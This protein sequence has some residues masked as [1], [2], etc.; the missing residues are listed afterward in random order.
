MLLK[1]IKLI[2]FRQFYGEEEIDIATD[3]IKNVTLIHAENGVGKTTILNAILWCFYKETTTNFSEPSKIISNQALEENIY[4]YGVSVTFEHSGKDYVVERK[5][6]KQFP[7]NDK[8]IAW[9][10]DRGNWKELPNPT[11]FI[12]SIVPKEMAKYFFIDGEYTEKLGNPNNKDEVRKALEDMMGCRTANMAIADLESIM[13]VTERSI[14]GLCKE[15]ILKNFQDFIEGCTS[16]IENEK[17]DL[18]K[19]RENLETAKTA[20]DLIRHQLKGS[21]EVGLIQEQREFYEKEKKKVEISLNKEKGELTQWIFDSGISLITKPLEEKTKKMLAEAKL[22]G[23]LP[24]LFAET[25][26]NSILHNKNCICK[27]SFEIDSAEYKEIENLLKTAGTPRVDDRLIDAKTLIEKLAARREVAQKSYVE[28]QEKIQTE[29]K[30]IDLLEVKINECDQKLQGSKIEEVKERNIALKNRI[31]EIS[32]NERKIGKLENEIERNELELDNYTKKRNIS[33]AEA[34][35]SDVFQKRKSLLIATIKKIKVELSNYREV[36]R[37]EI[38]LKINEILEKTTR[39][40]YSSTID[41]QFNLNMVFNENG[42]PVARSTGETQL[43]SLAFISALIKFSANRMLNQEEIFKPGTSSPL[44][45]DSPFGALDD[46][47]QESSASFLPNMAQQ[48]IL[49][50]SSSQFNS[51]VSKVLKEKIGKEYILVSENKSIQNNRTSDTI[52]INGADINCSLYNC[53]K[54]RTLI[55]IVI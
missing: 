12:E 54:N 17:N 34:N 33:L 40:A 42:Q 8:F 26:V 50:L 52:K 4:E 6:N 22:D 35:R 48:V 15:G 20:C 46:T 38:T 24:S 27:R 55:K 49:L 3:P 5:C 14:A 47:Y 7:D 37:N 16:K 21:A 29:T 28:I 23:K 41:Q 31:I 39:R 11:V 51:K 19:I 32:E 30:S 44:V 1:K 43:L 25:F 36:A 45:L 9:E 18:V 2:N 13:S 53:D 10:V